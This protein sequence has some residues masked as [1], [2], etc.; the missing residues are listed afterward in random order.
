MHHHIAD[1]TQFHPS[2]ET[3][4]HDLMFVSSAKRIVCLR[5]VLS[6][7][8]DSN[9]SKFFRSDTI[10]SV[11]NEIKCMSPAALASVRAEFFPLLISGICDLDS[12][13]FDPVM[14]LVQT[15]LA[16]R[17]YEGT[18]ACDEAS[19]L[20]F[21]PR[22]HHLIVSNGLH[23]TVPVME[24]LARCCTVELV[25]S[26]GPL[27]LIAGKEG[28]THE[29]HRVRVACVNLLGK[30]LQLSTHGKFRSHVDIPLVLFPTPCIHSGLA[31]TDHVWDPILTP[32]AL[33]AFATLLR[34]CQSEPSRQSSL[35]V[36]AHAILWLGRKGV[37]SM[38]P[39][40]MECIDAAKS[41]LF[42]VAEPKVQ[43]LA[44]ETI[45]TSLQCGIFQR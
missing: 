4:V 23:A 18:L 24:L 2:H 8:L 7:S 21:L 19:L 5:C 29:S 35:Y 43:Q 14:E 27:L 13:L 12:S 31:S 10:S 1:A 33:H 39:Q 16:Y 9:V 45:F 38:D 28:I 41:L 15:L 25:P 36:I 42:R 32:S 34:N 44:A 40:L 6:I 22:I 17:H 3:H 20:P 30:L 26:M 11:T 37:D